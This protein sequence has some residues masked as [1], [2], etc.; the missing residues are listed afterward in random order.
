MMLRIGPRR[1]ARLPA[2]P[3]Q[4][5]TARAVTRTRI[6]PNPRDA[7]VCAYVRTYVHLD[8]PN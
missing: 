6:K 2:F 5:V 4:R 1:N 8:A 3:L 7:H